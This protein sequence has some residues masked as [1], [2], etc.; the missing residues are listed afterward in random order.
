MLYRLL[1]STRPHQ[2][3]KNLF[4][5]PA[6]VFSGHVL[7]AEYVLRA[8][9]GMGCFCLL[10]GA[11]YLCNDILDLSQDRLHPEKS[12]RPIAAGQVPVSLAVVT[13]LFLFSLGLIGAFLL[14]PPFGGVAL[15]YTLLNLAYSWKLKQLVLIDVLIVAAGF[16][17]RAL[18]GALVIAVQISTWFILCTFTLALFLA[19]V[20]RRQELVVLAQGA[21][22][23][24]ATLEEYNLPFLDQVIAV[25]TSSALV[26]Y[27]LY[28]TGVGESQTGRHMQWTIPFV[29]YGIL[30]YLYLV[31]KLGEGANPTAVIWKDR[32]LQVTV[33]L[34]GLACA[35]GI[36]GLP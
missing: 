8:L 18:G 16:L 32:P 4:V 23:H 36:Y 29:L 31:Y 25:L 17:L 10:S 13:A 2:W 14:R 24:R 7:Q 22:Q 34:W 21:G 35:A 9:A 6:L 28:A 11:V 3:I 33:L 19:V 5:L 15:A 30:R 26:C 1:L 12:K 27:A 20:K